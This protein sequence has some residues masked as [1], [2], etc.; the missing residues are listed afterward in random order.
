MNYVSGIYEVCISKWVHSLFLLFSRSVPSNSWQLHGWQLARLPCPSLSPRAS[1]NSRPLSQWCHPTI[2]SS[3][4]PFSS[5]LQSFPASG[6]F[7]MIWLF[8]NELALR[9][10]WPK[11]WSLQLT[12]I[13]YNIKKLN[14]RLTLHLSAL[15]ILNDPSDEEEET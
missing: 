12:R 15:I 7:L 3:A 5:R 14:K 10:R 9:I 11:Y 13:W 1:S 8:S 6:S 2:S 4:I